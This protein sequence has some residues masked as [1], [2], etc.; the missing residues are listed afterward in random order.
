MSNTYL[1]EHYGFS[2]DETN[3]HDEV[4]LRMFTPEYL[5]QSGKTDS[6]QNLLP[7]LKQ[8]GDFDNT[9]V[10]SLKYGVLS[11]PFLQTARSLLL[12]GKSNIS[13]TP[14]LSVERPCLPEFEKLVLT[15]CL[16]ILRQ[17][18]LLW[19]K[20]TVDQDLAR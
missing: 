9:T 19:F 7:S 2:L 10:V 3:L 20:T 17:Y 8:Y 16:A 12:S 13:R 4:T 1:L 15:K 11:L 5:K 6:V 18:K 14:S